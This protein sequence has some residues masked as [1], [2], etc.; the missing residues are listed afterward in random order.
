MKIAILRKTIMK[1]SI[2]VG[3][4]FLLGMVGCRGV[5]SDGGIGDNRG[6]ITLWITDGPVDE[7]QKVTLAI[8]GFEIKPVGEP[9]IEVLRDELL[10]VDLLRLGDEDRPRERIIRDHSVPVGEYEWIR[11]LLDESRLS[12]ELKADGQERDLTI[13]A[14]KQEGLQLPFNVSIEDDTDLDLTIDLDLRKSLR[15]Q[16]DNE[17]E[18]HPSMRIVR[19]S[20]TGT[21]TGTV[22]RSLIEDPD[23]R[24][25]A[26][27]NRGN[28][29]YVFSGGDAAVQDIQGDP[30]DPVATT[31]VEIDAFTGEYEFRVGFLLRGN[32]T[33]AFTCDAAVDDPE[34]PNAIGAV[35]SDPINA[36]IEAGSTTSITFAEATSED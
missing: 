17:F 3:V 23:C 15:D 26:L 10:V 13:P 5:D 24:N 4:F 2:L 32:Y 18:L 16:G 11:L 12:I 28:A 27:N 29:V 6:E 7:A 9:A 8:T 19:T 22:A 35:F 36:Q 1:R 14:D 31:T 21:L 33:A 30:N 25:G 20:E 34:N